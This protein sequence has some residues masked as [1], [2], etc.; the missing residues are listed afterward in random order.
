MDYLAGI[1]YQ[2]SYQCTSTD[3]TEGESAGGISQRHENG[4]DESGIMLDKV[5]ET[6][7][8][9]CEDSSISQDRGSPTPD[10]KSKNEHLVESCDQVDQSKD[11]T[12]TKSQ[13]W[14]DMIRKLNEPLHAFLRFVTGMSARNPRTT[15]LLMAGIAVFLMVVGLSTN[16]LVDVDEDSLW[17]PRGSNAAIN[18]KW[19][20][21]ES[22]FK[23]EP[24]W[25]VLLFH[26]D[27]ENV[28]GQSQVQRMFDVLDGVRGVGGYDEMCSATGYFD[29]NGVQ[30]CEINGPPQIWNSSSAFFQSNVTSDAEAIQGLSVRFMLDLFPVVEDVFYGFPVRDEY[31][32]LTSV[33]SYSIFIQFP[34][35]DL[36][37]DVEGRALDVVLDFQQKWKDDP[38]SN[39]YVEVASER[40][41]P[42][43]FTRAIVTDLPLGKKR[44]ALIS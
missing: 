24:R 41:F 25:F 1:E 11:M 7:A 26:L 32:L 39:L 40:S 17:T 29:N 3:E 4:G 31:D 37:E 36:A 34:H 19:V 30:T 2:A 43:E 38:E 6:T 35:V 14:T 23:I 28:L 15:V 44:S 5:N 21:E 10:D 42:D 9:D 13:R 16:F 12:K 18:Q 22:G 33:T 20:K 27:G 8:T